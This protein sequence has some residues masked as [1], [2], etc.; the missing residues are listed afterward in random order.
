MKSLTVKSGLLSA[1]SLLVNREFTVHDLTKAYLNN[2]ACLHSS[3]KAARQFVYRNMLRLI[4]NGE[5]TKVVVDSGWP[6]YRLT[7][8][9]KTQ[10]CATTIVTTAPSAAPV[11]ATVTNDIPRQSL[12]ERL[13]RHKLEMLSAMGET[14]EYD[15]ICSEIPELQDDIQPLYNQSR[16]KC[17]KLLGRVKALE[18]LLAR[19]TG[20]AQ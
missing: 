5:L 7:P 1:F 17:S 20:L 19:Q 11:R 18:S 6:L 2:S 14:E 10:E 3:K 4:D 8:L 15:A 12:Q 16:D 9:F 13:N